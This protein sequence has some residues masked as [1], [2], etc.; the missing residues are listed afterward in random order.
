MRKPDKRIVRLLK[1]IDSGLSLAWNGRVNRWDLFS[2]RKLLKESERQKWDQVCVF[3]MNGKKHKLLMPKPI[4][5]FHIFFW[6]GPEGQ[7]RDL[8][9]NIVEDVMA[10]DM[11]KKRRKDAWLDMDRE[12]RDARV[13][14]KKQLVSQAQDWAREH[15][16][17][18]K[19]HLDI[20]RNGRRR[21]MKHFPINHAVGGPFKV[22]KHKVTK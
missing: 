21:W 18:R 13:L 6:E 22:K 8:T 15:P 4:D 14:K 20:M 7:Y 1:N 19:Q 16:H 9:T 3:Y 12:D 11:W 17:F 10:R 5:R 2:Q